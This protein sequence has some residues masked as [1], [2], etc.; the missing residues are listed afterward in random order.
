M[1]LNVQ[2][3]RNDVAVS[4]SGD[5]IVFASWMESLGSSALCAA[6]AMRFTA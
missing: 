2:C 3:I 4:E 6:H 5:D 1:N